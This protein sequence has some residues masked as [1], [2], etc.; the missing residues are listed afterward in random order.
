M[1]SINKILILAGDTD[2]NIGDRAIVFS[3]CHDFRRINPSVKIAIVSG[4]PKADCSFFKANATQRGVRGL[5]SLAKVAKESD[6]IL[7][8]G[9][10][11]FQDDDSLVKMP[12]WALRLL[13]IR[14]FCKTV[15][16]YSL[17]VGPLKRPI[18]R[19]FAKLAFGCMK[20]ISVRDPKAMKTAKDLTDKPVRIVPD[21]AIVLPETKQGQIEE[22]LA[23]NDI[24]LDGTPLIGVA[25]RRWFHHKAT[26]IPHKY[27]VKYHLRKIPGK[28]KCDKM[29]ALFAQVLDNIVRQYNAFTIFLPTYNV[30]HE[31]DYEICEQVMAKMKL[32]RTRL[33]KIGDPIQ[34]RAVAKYLKVMLGSRMHPTILAASAGTNIVGIAYNQKFSG[35]FELLGIPEKV[36]SIEDFVEYE[37]TD[38]AT[39]LIS[40]SIEQGNSLMP[41]VHSLADLIRNFNE[42]IL[43]GI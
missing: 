26:V 5:I 9:G 11:L 34:Y 35:F 16:G 6:L 38:K 19:F 7:C 25:L 33:L 42:E 31:A 22:L 29:T 30:S 13:F 17:G 4:N 23:T 8:G 41:V 28:E 24:P 20:G 10:G 21:P 1:A 14:C 39:A 27:A 37:L 43:A 12:Y 15:V 18:S 2:G 36:I 40:E 32:S 3:M